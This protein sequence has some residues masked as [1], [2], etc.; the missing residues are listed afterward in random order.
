M[1][2]LTNKDSSNF[3][4]Q[5]FSYR[6]RFVGKR[7][8]EHPWK[9]RGKAAN[10]PHRGYTGEE[11]VCK[12]DTSQSSVSRDRSSLITTGICRRSWYRLY[13]AKWPYLN[14][15]ASLGIDNIQTDK[16]TLYYIYIM[17][18][19]Q[20]YLKLFSWNSF[21]FFS[22]VIQVLQLVFI[23]LFYMEE[24]TVLSPPILKPFH[25]S[26]F[27]KEEW[28]LSLEIFS[29]KYLFIEESSSSLPSLEP[30]T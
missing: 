8:E 27:K 30:T 5:L 24:K 20:H 28:D 12:V 15:G 7:G 14:R 25:H 3:K 19:S 1:F 18:Y 10:L 17:L 9:S 6:Q 22:R 16:E 29:W 2:G 13:T 23:S 4:S 11:R 26:P 21:L